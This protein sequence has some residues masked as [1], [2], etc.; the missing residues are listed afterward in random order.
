[1][2]MTTESICES[3]KNN[4]TETCA[5]DR[6]RLDCCSSNGG[7]ET[8]LFMAHEIDIENHTS[9]GDNADRSHW[10]DVFGS[11]NEE[12]EEEG[13]KVDRSSQE[14]LFGSDD[15]EE[16]DAEVDLE[17]EL[18]SALDELEIFT[19][20]LKDYKKSIHEEFSQLR[21]CLEDSN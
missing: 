1:M 20:E 6:G 15:D 18:L 8:H 4:A 19:N 5:D 12:D 14:D 13:D 2:E 16:E 7:E 9:K 11:N 3:E 10:Y 21:T 17:G